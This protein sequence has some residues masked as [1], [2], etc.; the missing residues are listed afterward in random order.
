MA[1]FWIMLGFA[2][3][4]W[5]V[6]TSRKLPSPGLFFVGGMFWGPFALAAACFESPEEARKAAGSESLKP[7]GVAFLI[8]WAVCALILASSTRLSGIQAIGGGFF[9]SMVVT[10]WGALGYCFLRGLHKPSK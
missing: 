9:L 8:V 4:S 6:A 5:L 10:A 3:C 2:V 7:L 1:T